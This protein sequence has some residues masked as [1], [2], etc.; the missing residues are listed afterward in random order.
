[1][2]LAGTHCK[3]N[4]SAIVY[5]QTKEQQNHQKAHPF[6]YRIVALE[7]EKASENGKAHF[8]SCRAHQTKQMQP[9]VNSSIK[10]FDSRVLRIRALQN[11]GVRLE[12]IIFAIQFV[13][14]TLLL[15]RTV[16]ISLTV[17]SLGLF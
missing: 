11:V 8:M 3:S 7:K 16:R 9:E 6:R 12:L 13:F 2:V 17:S 15:I 14:R 10:Q 4:D 5:T 1:M